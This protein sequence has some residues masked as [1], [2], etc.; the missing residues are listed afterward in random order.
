LL[1]PRALRLLVPEFLDLRMLWFALTGGVI[2]LAISIVARFVGPT[3]GTR[4][5][6][7]SPLVWAALPTA[8][9]LQKGN[10]QGLIVATSLIAM[11]LFERRHYAGGGMLLGFAA[12][13]KLYPGLLLVYLLAQRQW[14][15]AIWTVTMSLGMAI[16]TL[17]DIGWA[18]FAAFL[19]HLPGL[20]GGEAFPAFRNPL[21]MA[22]NFSVPGLAFK[23]KLFGIPGM[24]FG[25]AKI[26]G[27][28]YTLVAL[29]ATV[30][31]ARRAQSTSEKPLLW[32]AVL[33]LAT[34]RSPFLPQ[35]YAAFPPLWLL[36]LLAAT[37]F[38]SARTLGLTL[39]AWAMFNI[40]W[41]LDWPIEPRA[42]ALA[43][44]VPQVLTVVLVVLAVRRRVPA[45]L[46]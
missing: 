31:A 46:T 11:V 10:V 1:L 2:L 28:I 7:L 9:T 19:D 20:V 42:L 15:A 18:P 39:A 40:Y 3:A 17:A 34:L 21:A 12:I 43:N 41:P 24:G 37:Y 6:L 32:L 30:L 44:L 22:V 33:I 16:L 23:L 13:S 38:P 8:S 26:L 5:L 45:T 4:A 14:R 25:A 27:W 29:A 35:A 36:T